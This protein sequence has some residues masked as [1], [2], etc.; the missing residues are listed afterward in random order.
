MKHW[1]RNNK[2]KGTFYEKK[3]LLF[4]QSQKLKLITKNYHSRA[5]E[6]DIIML[7]NN[8]LVFVEVRFRSNKGF[9]GGLE[10]IDFHKQDKIKKTAAIFLQKHKQYQ[11]ANCRFD[12]VS[13]AKNQKNDDT[14]D[15]IQSA[16]E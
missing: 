11:D 3:A 6:I 16:F 2:E 1:F 5:G 12:V 14:I 8:I 15:W 7:D 10:S 9:G 13:L 4:L